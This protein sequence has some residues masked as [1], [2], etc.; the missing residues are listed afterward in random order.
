MVLDGRV[1]LVTPNRNTEPLGGSVTRHT[2][3]VAG[4]DVAPSTRRGRGDTSKST[5]VR[6]MDISDVDTQ[7]GDD[8]SALL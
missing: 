5:G 6:K 3:M 1:V 2:F 7:C 8:W 4:S